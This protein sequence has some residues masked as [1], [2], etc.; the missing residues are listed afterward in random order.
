MPRYTAVAG[1]LMRW[2]QYVIP[3]SCGRNAE[4]SMTYSAA[5]TTTFRIR[6][7]PQLAAARYQA[8]VV[9]RFSAHVVY[10]Y[11]MPTIF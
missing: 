10:A 6:V 8:I 4:S 11:R 9:D 7:L 3:S 2:L 5:S 1:G